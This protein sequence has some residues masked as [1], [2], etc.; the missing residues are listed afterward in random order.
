[1][2]MRFIVPLFDEESHSL[3]GIFCAAYD[4]RTQ[5]ALANYDQEWLRDI[6]H[7]FEKH[8]RVP[9]VL[10]RPRRFERNPRTICWMKD[11]ALEHLAKLHELSILLEQHGRSTKVLK[12]CRPGVVAYEDDFQVAAIPYRDTFARAR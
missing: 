6:L 12:T 10:F 2:Y 9:P 7:W 5:H 1:M 11:T 8:L 3:R 4:L